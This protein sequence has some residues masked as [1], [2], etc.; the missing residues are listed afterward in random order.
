MYN[1][2]DEGCLLVCKLREK[3]NVSQESA[4]ISGWLAQIL[5]HAPA[6]VLAQLLASPAA[7]TIAAT[8][9]KLLIGTVA[10]LQRKVSPCDFGAEL[11]H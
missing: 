10:T 5:D 11:I 8:R 4:W 6:A 9:Q 3:L 1:H 2:H 7:A